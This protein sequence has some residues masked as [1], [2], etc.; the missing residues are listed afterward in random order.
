MGGESKSEQHSSIMPCLKEPDV[1][2]SLAAG[3]AIIRIYQTLAFVL[4]P[5]SLA[6]FVLAIVKAGKKQAGFRFLALSMAMMAFSAFAF[7]FGVA[8]FSEWIGT[9]AMAVYTVG[10]VPVIQ[11]FEVLGVYCFAKVFREGANIHHSALCPLM[12]SNSA[13]GKAVANNS[14]IIGS[15]FL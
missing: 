5:L 3:T 8:W 13:T 6:G 12:I 1:R 2:F 10:A 11:V 4:V 7:V 15:H 9:G 14:S